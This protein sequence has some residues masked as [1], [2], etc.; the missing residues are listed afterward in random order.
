MQK[1]LK[2]QNLS[3]IIFFGKI[4]SAG[5][6]VAGYIFLGVWLSNWLVKNG[7]SFVI[8]LLAIVFTTV[9]G[10]W[11][12]WLFVRTEIKKINQKKK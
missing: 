7:W 5:L 10:I 4:L 9:F 3:E 8:S 2:N 12:G 1:F 11:Q 6:V